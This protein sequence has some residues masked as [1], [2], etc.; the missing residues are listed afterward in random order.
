[1]VIVL[2]TNILVAA[3]LSPFGASFQILTMIPHRRFDLLLSVPLM[4]EATLMSRYALEIPEA[5][6][7][8]AQQVAQAQQASLDDFVC[9]A[10]AEKIAASHT[11]QY[12]RTRAGRA[13]PQAFLAVLDRIQQAAG[14]VVEGDEL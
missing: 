8:A 12:F 10:I 14:S 11:A 3:T 7:R 2:D 5:L 1:M 6:A 13:D 4:L 9:V